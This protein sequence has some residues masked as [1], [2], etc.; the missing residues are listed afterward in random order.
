MTVVHFNRH[1]IVLATLQAAAD[2]GEYGLSYRADVLA[3]RLGIRSEQTLSRNGKR[4]Y[5]RVDRRIKRGVE[6][7]RYR[8]QCLACS[9]NFYVDIL[10]KPDQIRQWERHVRRHQHDPL[11]SYDQQA[12]NFAVLGA[13]RFQEWCE[14]EKLPFA[15]MSHFQTISQGLEKALKGF[16]RKE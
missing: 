11:V 7:C 14:R 4:V 2:W 9:A 8:V 6:Q 10:A 3:R 12:T 5:L 15:L 1:D 16:Q 13:E